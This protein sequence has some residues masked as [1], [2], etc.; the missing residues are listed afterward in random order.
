[1]EAYYRTG[2]DN[3]MTPLTSDDFEYSRPDCNLTAFAVIDHL[4]DLLG[5]PAISIDGY[6]MRKLR[7]HP[8]VI[9]AQPGDKNP[10]GVIVSRGCKS[11]GS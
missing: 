9:T 8:A 1:M 3:N 4:L 6:E 5:K 2:A 11:C 10:G 7:Q